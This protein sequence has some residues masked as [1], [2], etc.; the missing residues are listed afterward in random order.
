MGSNVNSLFFP[1]PYHTILRHFMSAMDDSETFTSLLFRGNQYRIIIWYWEWKTMNTLID[2]I[3]NNPV[4]VAA[5]FIAFLALIL[6][7]WEGLENRRN[8]RLSAQP[9]LSILEKWDDEGYL[10]KLVLSN[11]GFGPAIIE[12][13]IYRFASTAYREE[14]VQKL[15]DTLIVNKD[16]VKGYWGYLYP[17]ASILPNREQDLIGFQYLK[18]P[19][20]L[21]EVEKTEIGD[22]VTNL[23]LVT[24]EVTYRSIFNRKFVKRVL[25]GQTGI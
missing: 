17:G 8:N 19:N 24:I 2:F 25:L 5:T 10:Y 20:R 1:I 9:I 18:K 7:I 4:D 11:D 23:G 14:Q 12:G 22:T 21:L 6:T 16:L 3:K 15:M 13:I